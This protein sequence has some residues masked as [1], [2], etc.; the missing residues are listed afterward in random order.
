MNDVKT[1]CSESQQKNTCV[2]SANAKRAATQACE[3]AKGHIVD[4]G[5]AANWTELASKR[6]LRLPSSKTRCTR[7]GME[8]WLRRLGLSTDWYREYTGFRSLSEWIAANPDW[9]LK[10]FVGLML[11]ECQ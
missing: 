5:D 4:P 6:G 8:K 7:G 2:E 3:M 9:P 1:A 10:A 11:E